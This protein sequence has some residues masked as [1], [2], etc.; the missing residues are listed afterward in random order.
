MRR[1]GIRSRK[2]LASDHEPIRILYDDAL[3]TQRR[4]AAAYGITQGRISQILT[5]LRA[6]QAS[7]QLDAAGSVSPMVERGYRPT[8]S[9]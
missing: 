6:G 4:I 5:E 9:G 2:I 3:W 7:M 1:N 8:E